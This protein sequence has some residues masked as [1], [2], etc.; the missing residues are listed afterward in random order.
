MFIHK[1]DH[2]I[3]L[4]KAAH[5]VKVAKDS[6]ERTRWSG[7][8]LFMIVQVM[9]ALSVLTG[10]IS[11]QDL[12]ICNGM[13]RILMKSSLSQYLAKTTSWWFLGMWESITLIKTKMIP[14]YVMCWHKGPKVLHVEGG[15]EVPQDEWSR[16]HSVRLSSSE[17]KTYSVEH[18]KSQAPQV[19]ANSRS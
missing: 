15:G 13:C 1:I 16:W 19:C 9:F 17:T 4:W 5:E 12:T 3:V 11:I 7:M 2:T 8:D 10:S 6:S 14:F 18:E